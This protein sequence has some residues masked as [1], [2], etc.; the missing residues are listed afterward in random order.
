VPA[1]AVI[2]EG[3]AARVWVVRPDGLL[4]S[5]TV[6]AGDEQDGQVVIQSGLAPG[7]RIVTSGA[8]FVNEAG[9][10]A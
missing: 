7:E 5:R 4:Q 2:H 1:A 3:E 6:V 9:L 8:L 10:G